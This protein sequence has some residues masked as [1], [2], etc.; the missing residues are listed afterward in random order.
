MIE[1]I[2]KEP[3]PENLPVE[4]IEKGAEQKRAEFRPVDFS[5]WIDKIFKGVESENSQEEFLRLKK[6]VKMRQFYRG[7]QRGFFS[8]VDKTYHPINLDE[9]TPSEQ[10]LLLVNNQIRPKVRSLTKEWT[11]SQTRLHAQPT[12]NTSKT[13]KAARFA[14]SLLIMFQ[15]KLIDERFKQREGKN[16][17]LTGNYFR[18]S[19]WSSKNSNTNVR[20]PV[21]EDKDITVGNPVWHCQSCNDAGQAEELNG[22]NE[23]PTCQSQLE[24]KSNQVNSSV[25]SGYKTLKSGEPFTELVDPTEVKIHLRARSISSSPY[26][27]RR[28]LVMAKALKFQFPYAQI[29]RTDFSIASTYSSE[30]ETSAGNDNDGGGA[31]GGTTS[32][33]SDSND[34]EMVEFKQLWLDVP[35]YYDVVLDKPLTLGSGDIIPAGTNLIDEFPNGMYIARCGSANL[36]IGSEDKN[37]LWTHGC[38]D[39]IP[40]SFW[41]DG[42]DDLIQSQQLINEIQSLIVENILHNA[43]AKIIFNPRLINPELLTGRPR[44]MTPMSN[45]ARADTRP[46]DAFAQISGMSITGEAH[47]AIAEAKQDMT[48]Q[49]GAYLSMSGGIDPHLTTATSM[50]IARDSGI[51]NLAPSLAIKANVESE[52]GKQILRIFKENWYNDFDAYSGILGNYSIAEAQAFADCDIEAD[53]EI[54][55]EA[56]SWMPRTDLELRQDF[57]QFLTAMGLPLGFANPEIPQEI[58]EKAE[59]LFRVPIEFN[60]LQPDIRWANIRFEQL[61]ETVM[62]LIEMGAITGQETDEKTIQKITQD[63]PI[64]LYIDDHQIYIDTYKELKKTDKLIF[65]ASPSLKASLDYMILLH[66]D[67]IEQMNGEATDAENEE[68]VNQVATEGAIRQA[69]SDMTEEEAPQ[70]NVAP[71]DVPVDVGTGR[72][73]D[74]EKP[75]AK[76]KKVIPAT[77]RQ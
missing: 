21:Y 59:S 6:W 17:F 69:A 55:A 62:Q 49:S 48:E 13:K 57:M 51:G 15:K 63:I 20:V 14:E 40:E 41:G 61:E 29:K 53:I 58:R 65:M 43:S 25:L 11:K 35:F 75:T 68:V 46:Q 22:T 1:G 37:N 60:K 70:S 2:N 5:Q 16:N 73:T 24:I 9:Y 4:D 74:T 52:W 23:C 66:Q 76:S 3:H 32:D 45:S 38:Y 47:N 8:P 30:M 50:A 28:R 72:E 77:P 39:I 71:Q 42:L 19:Y 64:D 34:F 7:H 10:S 33:G 18:F 31:S 56:G 36:D 44:E 27:L 12:K 26:L 67:A 54:V